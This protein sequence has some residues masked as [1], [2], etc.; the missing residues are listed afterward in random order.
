MATDFKSR[1]S[2][3]RPAK[4]ELP[5]G[6]S[7]KVKGP[8]VYPVPECLSGLDFW[9]AMEAFKRADFDNSDSLELPEFS[10][11][12]NAQFSD[13]VGQIDIAKLYSMVYRNNSG[14]IDI[15]EFLSWIW[16]VPQV[17]RHENQLISPKAL[18]RSMSSP[19][20]TASPAS[21]S[22]PLSP[23]SAF[24]RTSRFEAAEPLSPSSPKT[25]A[26]PTSPGHRPSSSARSAMVGDR[27]SSPSTMLGRMGQLA[28]LKSSKQQ[29]QTENKLVIV[30]TVGPDFENHTPGR[31]PK[32]ASRIERLKWCVK[33]YLGNTVEVQFVRDQLAKGVSKAEALLGSGVVVWRTSSMMAFREDPFATLDAVE[34]WVKMMRK[35]YI[36]LLIRIMN[37]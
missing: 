35:S 20:M 28:F 5:N 16:S 21:P 4:V 22:S 30:F 29:T 2:T 13:F 10:C 8:H 34:D 32:D 18:K 11:F 31:R 19:S 36:P 23:K 3:M 25:P 24:S 14:Q 15:E 37:L 12:V 1:V 26:S 7:R 27:M 6:R 33:E 9:Q 17:N